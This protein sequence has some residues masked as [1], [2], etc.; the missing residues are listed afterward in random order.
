MNVAVAFLIV[1]VANLMRSHLLRLINR[2]NRIG[3]GYWHLSRS[4]RSCLLNHSTT[5]VLIVLETVSYLI[6]LELIVLYLLLLLSRPLKFEINRIRLLL[7]SHTWLLLLLFTLHAGLILVDS[8]TR[9][10]YLVVVLIEW[11]SLLVKRLPS[12]D[13]LL[14]EVILLRGGRWSLDCLSLLW[15]RGYLIWEGASIVGDLE[16]AVEEVLVDGLG[17][18]LVRL[19]AVLLLLYLGQ[20]YLG[21]HRLSVVIGENIILELI[22]LLVLYLFRDIT[23]VVIEVNWLINI[24]EL[25]A[26][27]NWLLSS[28]SSIV[29]GNLDFI[30]ISLVELR[31]SLRISKVLE[32]AGLAALVD[33]VEFQRSHWPSLLCHKVLKTN[34]I[35]QQLQQPISRCSS[36]LLLPKYT[37]K[38]VLHS[39]KA[40]HSPSLNR[41]LRIVWVV[42]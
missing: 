25:L 30:E 42:A 20:C 32:Q 35:L 15:W 40:L 11:L 4:N 13:H 6:T 12:L 38:H 33:R 36:L 16:V 23:S 22:I 3:V 19:L 41:P 27:H 9:R 1:F 39:I 8:P 14:L 17:E 34:R 5:S 2:L 18:N 31:L 37:S 28:L 26:S 24:S 21:W 29:E 7:L 10:E